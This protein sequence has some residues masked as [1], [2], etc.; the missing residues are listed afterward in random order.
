MSCLFYRAGRSALSI[1]TTLF[2]G[3]SF[4]AVVCVQDSSV[5]GE[6]W[7]SK[8]K[9]NEATA[10]ST[11]RMLTI[12]QE[13]Y[14]KTY[15]GKGYAPDLTTLGPGPTGSCPSAGPTAAT[16]CIIDARLGCAEGTKGVFC[17]KNNY[18]FMLQG[19]GSNF[20][21][22]CDDYII[23]ATPE[24]PSDGRK[25]ICAISDF[26]VRWRDVSKPPSTPVSA[27]DCEKWDPI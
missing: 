22:C 9:A 26:I 10:A 3:L 1:L 6:Y 2:V 24:S 13:K 5:F 15:R 4:L 7:A 27:A 11:V 23:F 20:G 25:D 17:T 19:I 14:S 8:R 18:K 12:V 21:K 16:A